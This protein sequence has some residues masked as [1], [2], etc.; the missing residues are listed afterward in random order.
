MPFG[1]LSLVKQLSQL[2]SSLNVFFSLEARSVVSI[3]VKVYVRRKSILNRDTF[4]TSLPSIIGVHSCVPTPT[5]T[6]SNVRNQF[7]IW[8]IKNAAQETA[9]K[10]WEPLAF[11]VRKY[12]AL[13]FTRAFE[14]ATFGEAQTCRRVGLCLFC[15]SI[16]KAVIPYVLADDMASFRIGRYF[17]EMSQSYVLLVWSFVEMC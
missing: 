13:T 14:H 10:Y 8:S 12:K 6:D 9:K 11:R 3:F 5:R 4:F 7:N 16:V 15:F 1:W 2:H 17:A